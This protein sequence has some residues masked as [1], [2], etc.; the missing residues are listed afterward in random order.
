VK[1]ITQAIQAA[2]ACAIMLAMVFSI[3]AVLAAAPL[4][5]GLYVQSWK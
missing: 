4:H 5:V 1:R 3:P 2:L